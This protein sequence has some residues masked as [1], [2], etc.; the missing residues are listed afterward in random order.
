MNIILGSI[1]FFIC[2]VILTFVNNGIFYTFGFIPW[3]YDIPML[4]VI[5]F[6]AEIG[7]SKSDLFKLK[8]KD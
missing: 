4:M 1:R 8:D 2:V 6:L 3:Y 5:S 7:F